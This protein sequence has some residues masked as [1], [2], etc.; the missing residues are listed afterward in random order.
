MNTQNLL[1]TSPLPASWHEKAYY[2]LDAYCKNTYGEKL[3]KIALDA[4]FTCP[5]RDGT[6]DT[7]GCIFCSAGGSGDFAE[8]L[9]SPSDFAHALEEGKKRLSGKQTGNQ[10]IAYFQA[11][12]GTYAPVSY[13]KMVYQKALSDANIAGISIATRPDCLSKDVLLLLAQLKKAYPNKF[14]WIELGLQTI[15]ENTA[16]FI[17]RGYELS[18]FNQALTELEK[19]SI[20]VIV[21]LILGL[22]GET[23]DDMLASVS[24]LNDKPVWG[25]KLQLLHILQE[26]DLAKL[27]FENP[28]KIC[29][30]PDMDTY[31][32][33]VI[34]CL[35][36][37]RQDMVIHRV[38][39]DA[40]KSLLL[41]P[42]WSSNK[43]GILNRL[44]QKIKERSAYQGRLY[45]KD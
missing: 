41:A 18:C 5:N 9:S 11:Y 33:T 37:L 27:Y 16:T 2:S 25:I 8:K 10:F 15:H 42:K 4:G 26:T 38:T 13:L 1:Q 31:L 22:P 21:H 3:Y 28:D 43:R 36:I 30:F 32:D 7:R 19:L 39:G 45:Q 23:K 29:T 44:H 6:L 34:D 40:P 20:P 12:T 24:Y 14:I 35:E 17:R